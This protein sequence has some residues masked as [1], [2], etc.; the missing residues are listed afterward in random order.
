MYRFRADLVNESYNKKLQQLVL[1]E[2][3]AE[4]FNLVLEDTNTF[5]CKTKYLYERTTLLRQF[6]EQESL[7]LKT[8]KLFVDDKLKFDD[9]RELKREYQDISGVLK[10][11]FDSVTDK[12]KRINRQLAQARSSIED[13]FQVYQ[14][15]DTANKKQIVDWISPTEVNAQTGEVSIQI[16]RAL[17]KILCYK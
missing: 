2:G 15:M 10:K 3:V 1:S 7:I 6:E 13:I 16:N 8:R 4:L 12:L 17:T 9:F 14:F 11:E 5:V